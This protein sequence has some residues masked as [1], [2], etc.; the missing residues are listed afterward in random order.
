MCERFWHPFR[1]LAA[2]APLLAF[3]ETESMLMCEH[4][5]A[6]VNARAKWT[7]S[8]KTVTV[9]FKPSPGLV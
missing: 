9:F 2:L 6:C 8:K 3:F 7:D 4:L 5:L 1:D